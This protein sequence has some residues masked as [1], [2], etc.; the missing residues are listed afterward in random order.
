M[1]ME[2]IKQVKVAVT[3]L[4]RSVDWY[5]AVFELTLAREFVEHGRVAGAVV[6]PE[7]RRFLIGLRLRSRIVGTP[8]FAGFDLFSLG[9]ASAAELRT[10]AERCEA[11]AVEHGGLVD[12]GVDGV[13]LDITDPDGTVVR[14]LSPF[15]RD[16]PPF[17][18]VDF[19]TGD[20]PPVTYLEPRL[21]RYSP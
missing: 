5:C 15:A 19:G 6:A 1:T 7:N 3:D 13:H 11:L 20:A 16:T 9:A 4:Q 14:V 12:R 8:S 10:L 18:G 21:A 2:L 17:L